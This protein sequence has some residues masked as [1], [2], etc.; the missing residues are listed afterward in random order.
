MA[1]E[2]VD[3]HDDGWEFYLIF[4]IHRRPH[5]RSVVADDTD[6][7]YILTYACPTL[8]IQLCTLHRCDSIDECI[9]KEDL[10]MRGTPAS[11]GYWSDRRKLR[12]L[13]YEGD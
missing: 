9:D 2:P 13:A 12:R 7:Y 10:L 4:Y 5:I 6:T 11:K 3:K 8:S 1:F